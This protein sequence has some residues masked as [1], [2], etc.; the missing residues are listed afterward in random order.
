MRVRALAMLCA[1]SVCPVGA[2]SL[3]HKLWIAGVAALA[4]A[5]VADAA[6]SWGKRELNLILPQQ[7]FGVE[8]A[9]VKA[10]I[11]GA[12]MGVEYRIVRRHPLLR[13]KVAAMNLCGAGLDAVIVAH[14][15]TVPK[16]SGVSK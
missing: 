1:L 12:F 7:R 4:A 13:R 9:L 6:S 5:N 8:D 10:G 14:N 16:P 11:V 2:A 3:P 15:L